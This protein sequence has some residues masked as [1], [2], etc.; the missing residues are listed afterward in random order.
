MGGINTHKYKPFLYWSVKDFRRLTASG[1]MAA[2]T[3][4][5]LARRQQDEQ[6]VVWVG[7][8]SYWT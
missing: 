4:E 3:S 6:A 8:A 5:S 1:G 7:V 2:N